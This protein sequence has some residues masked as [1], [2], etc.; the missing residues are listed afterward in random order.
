MFKFND[1]STD[2]FSII[3][4][5]ELNLLKKASQRYNII[6]VPGKNGSEYEPQGYSDV[7]IPLKLQL[8]DISKLSEIYSWLNGEGVLEYNNK[9][10][11]AQIYVE[12]N[13]VRFGRIYTIDITIIREPFW[14]L[15]KDEYVTIADSVE[16]EGNISSSPIIRL[17]KITD[18]KVDITIN[19]V[20]F[21]YNFEND[22]YAEFD[23]ESCDVTM[24]NLNRNKNIEID[25]IIPSLDPGKNI[26]IKNVGDCII[27]MKRKD[28]FL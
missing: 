15:I 9:K 7:E 10:A 23:C 14:Y 4:E 16:N 28:R 5:E 26:V 24:N 17:E 25:F 19:G 20:R 8:L 2:D 22:T 3:A 27:K 12:Q 6:E 11:K 21:K 13:P 18:Q 1:K